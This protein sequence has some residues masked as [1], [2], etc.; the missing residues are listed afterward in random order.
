MPQDADLAA[1]IAGDML[2][3]G[4]PAATAARATSLDPAT[5]EAMETAMA[6]DSLCATTGTGRASH[7]VSTRHRAAAPLSRRTA[8]AI[9][10]HAT[11]MQR[12]RPQTE[13][14]LQ[15]LIAGAASRTRILPTADVRDG[16]EDH[17]SR[18]GRR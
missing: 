12:A 9:A 11:R 13:A 10:D 16:A 8:E 2:R 7:G 15:A 5:V 4:V 17:R 3:R 18:S 14:E 1:T 6:Y